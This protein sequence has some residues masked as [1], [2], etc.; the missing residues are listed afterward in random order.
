MHE[1]T[2]VRLVAALRRRVRGA[3]AEVTQV[4]GLSCASVLPQAIQRMH[5]SGVVVS[6]KPLGPSAVRSLP[7]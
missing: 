2:Q 5:A 4:P 6:G 3:L 1:P 7:R